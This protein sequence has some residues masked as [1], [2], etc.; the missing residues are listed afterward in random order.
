MSAPLLVA[1]G[2]R[3]YYGAA[4]AL[5]GVDFELVQG[6]VAALIGAN[7]A[8]KTTLLRAICG[9][10]RTEGELTFRGA[11]LP[12]RSPEDVARLGVAHVADGRGTFL[13]LSVE[14]NLRL[15]AHT[16]RDKPAVRR[17]LE[18]M[19]ELFPPLAGRRRQQAG[20]LSGGEQ[21]MLAMARALM[22]RPRLLIVDE[23]SF[24]LAPLRA[25]EAFAILKAINRSDGV[26]L[27]IV[28]QN[29]RL[30]LDIASRAYLMQAGRIVS[31]GADDAVRRAY[32]GA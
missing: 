10:I 9:L 7:G 23:P 13:S 22:M 17:D 12:R 20:A 2:L 8:G 21:Q 5:H 4:E 18:R 29:V 1:R 16:R 15:G 11:P 3:A 14:E 27:L 6:G 32:L 25:A 28:E 30:A 19:F 26:A 24:G 31:S